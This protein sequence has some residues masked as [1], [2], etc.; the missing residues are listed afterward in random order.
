MTDL[1]TVQR[2][3]AK[4]LLLTVLGEFVLPAGGAAWTSTLVA[5]AGAL[6]I[7]E[8]NARQAV[9]RIGEDG[10]VAAARHGRRTRWTL[11]GDGM[12]LLEAGADRIYRFGEVVGDWDGHWLLAH[13]PVAE[14][15]RATRNQLRTQLAFLGFGELSPSLLIS[16]H[17]ERE[18][19]L[20]AVLAELDLLSDSIVLRSTTTDDDER[21]DLVARAWDLD[22]LANSYAMF[23]S[24][25][26]SCEPTRPEATFG[27]L[28]ELVHSWR[29]FPFIDPELP[30]ELLPD[31]W[32]GTTAA[33]VFRRCRAAWSPTAQHW[34]AELEAG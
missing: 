27:A 4:S 11:T 16:P 2:G 9:A 29:R 18:P 15:Q 7:G 10:L 34:F 17:T 30:P 31:G 21:R 19:Q 14:S 24:A 23:R 12:R 32:A 20:R 33:S 22:G 8:K 25:H 1:L 5:A 6:G 26:E 13:S 3:G 28:V